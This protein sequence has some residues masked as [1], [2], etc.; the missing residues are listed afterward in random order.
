MIHTG[1]KNTL[2]ALRYTSVGMYLGDDEGNDVLLPN[3]YVPDDL[4]EEDSIEV[5]I[6]RDS[7]DRIIATNLVPYLYL[8]EFAYLKVNS[9]SAVGAFMDM[10]LEKDLLVP[11]REQITQLDVDKWATVCLLRDPQTDRLVGSCHVNRY[12]EFEDIDLTA[13]EQVQILV[14][15]H[16]DLGYNVIINNKYRGLIYANEVF[17]EIRIGKKLTLVGSATEKI[18]Q[19]LQKN[20]GFSSLTDASEPALIYARLEMS[21]KNFKKAIGALYRERK[22]RIETNGIYLV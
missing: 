12:L 1:Q 15:E 14:Y 16:S 5:F 17:Q 13:G 9:V 20:N 11:F 22:I 4:K 3:K 10:G 7:E 2:T 19:L 8:N 18:I 21:K 6:Y